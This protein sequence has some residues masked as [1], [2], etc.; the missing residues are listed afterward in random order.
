MLGAF[1]EDIR[2][3]LDTALKIACGFGGGGMRYKQTC[4]AISGATMV[5]GLKCGQHI[6]G[7]NE[8]KQNC[9]KKIHEF[10]DKFKEKNGSVKCCDLLGVGENIDIEM[11]KD[12]LKMKSL[13]TS[14]CVEFVK[15]AV[16]I[17]ETMEF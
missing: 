15:S 17:L 8:S 16:Q 12:P 2:L 14:V 5:I 3:D 7:D 6:K 1:C 4:G 11:Q 13:F 9:Y 10:T